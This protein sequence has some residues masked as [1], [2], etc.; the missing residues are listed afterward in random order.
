MQVIVNKS[1]L[2]TFG[3]RSILVKIK[4]DDPAYI[5]AIWH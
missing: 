3:K 1:Y 5:C 4:K 2:E